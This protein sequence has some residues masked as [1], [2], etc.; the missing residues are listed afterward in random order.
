M[1]TGENVILFISDKRYINYSIAGGVQRCTSEFIEYFYQ[2]GYQLEYF[3]ID[4]TKSITKR[5]KIK[6]GIDVYDKYDFHKYTEA[7]INVVNKHNI[8]LIALNQLNLSPLILKIRPYL[9]A[10]VKFIGLSHGNESGDYIHDI[11]KQRRP[12]IR[13]TWKLGKQIVMENFFFSNFF[14]GVIV[15]SEHEKPINEWLGSKNVFF[16]PRLLKSEFIQ[17][18]PKEKRIGFAGTLDHLP[19]SLGLKYLA[20]ALQTYNFD[21]ELRIVGSPNS[22]G[23]TLQKNYKFIKYLGQL[24]NQELEREVTTWQLFLNPVFW[25]SRGSSTKL[26]QAINWGIP[27]VSTPAGKRGYILEDETIV[28]KDHLPDTFARFILKGINDCSFLSEL[29]SS[30]EKNAIMFNSKIWAEELK[31]FIENVLN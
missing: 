4:S 20:T 10:N 2:A 24:S 30:S 28:T 1:E 5:I 16:L 13:E 18:I 21:G 17:W 7:I 9:P 27:V 19:N 3:T 15:I 22:Y 29:K 25:Y 23:N 8:K 12:S 6:L 26:A 11:T 31:I 14:N